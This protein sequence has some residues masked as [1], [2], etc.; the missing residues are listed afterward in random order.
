MLQTQTE[1]NIITKI[2]HHKKNEV[3]KSL[4]QTCTTS[5]TN[6]VG[7]RENCEQNDIQIDIIRKK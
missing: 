3:K 7:H 2:S 4:I 5:Y 6:H 1:K